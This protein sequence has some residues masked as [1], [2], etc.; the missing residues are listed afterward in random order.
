MIYCFVGVKE[1]KLKMVSYYK[2]FVLA[3]LIVIIITSVE[4]KPIKNKIKRVATTI[5]KQITYEKNN[6]T[7]K[8]IL[9]DGNSND[10]DKV[11]EDNNIEQYWI[12]NTE[13]NPLP[14]S[15]FEK[16]TSLNF[17]EHE[18]KN[19]QSGLLPVFITE[20][21]DAYATRGSPAKI[22]CKAAHALEVSTE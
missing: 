4:S 11:N 9:R 10:N 5:D 6:N 20:P 3:I 18:N 21:E 19:G 13:I 2:L 12:G 17:E 8:N 16:S 7:K 1:R 15:F 22:I 14:N